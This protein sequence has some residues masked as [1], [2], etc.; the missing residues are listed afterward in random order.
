YAGLAKTRWPGRLEVFS[1]QPFVLLDGAH[2]PSAVKTLRKF[3]QNSSHFRRLIMVVGI[4]GDKAWKP[5]LRQLA[6]VAD[7]MILTSPQY[8]RAADPHE[9]A[10]FVRTFVQ[11]LVVIPHLPD[12]V[13][14]ALEE[15][16][17]ADAVCITG[18]LYTV[19]DARAYLASRDVYSA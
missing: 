8:E 9:L 13:S 4:L 14:L 11:D 5:M 1:K 7:R 10:S 3:L 18:S 19:G 6:G 16:G 12:A 17:P 15:A 2:N